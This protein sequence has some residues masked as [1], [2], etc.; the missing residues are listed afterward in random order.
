[1][2]RAAFRV[3][4][5]QCYQSTS[6]TQLARDL[7][8]TKSALYRHFDCKEA[9]ENAMYK[10]YYDEYAAFLK[11]YCDKALNSSDSDF[12]LLI[13][14]RAMVAYYARNI[15]AF[16][17]AL[18]QVDGRRNVMSVIKQLQER[19]IDILKLRAMFT[20]NQGCP[21][22]IQALLATTTYWLAQFHR[23]RACLDTEPDDEQV[24]KLVM[25]IEENVTKGLG[26]ERTTVAR[27]DYER[28]EALARQ[29]AESA[30]SV[31]GNGDAVSAIADR[32][33]KAAA[34]VVAELG[35]DASMDMVA[36]RAGM[37]KSGLYAHFK[38]KQDML[39]Q[40][41]LTE[42]DRIFARTE[43]AMR[44]VDTV[45]EKLYMSIVS[46]A[47]YLRSYPEIL[48][49][50]DWV[51]T[52]QLKLNC[53]VPP[54]LYRIFDEFHFDEERFSHVIEET[55]N[56]EGRYCT[57][58]WIGFLIMNLL[59]SRPE[60]MDFVDIPDESVRLLYQVITCGMGGFKQ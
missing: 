53:S 27:L 16:L 55:N 43:A 18:V 46:I 17:F 60:D 52:R 35:P 58:R 36:Q 3:W 8:V 39:T 1:I 56:D 11:P 47:D 14:L 22:Q 13:I 33:L 23:N 4:G 34:S 49:A 48:L 26:Y 19:G 57:I 25:F 51:R 28:L 40:L 9:L 32:L 41:F 59:M 38:N 15:D 31:S 10:T 5:Q 21:T 50:M 30:P 44:L 6:L 54:R 12:A 42:F 7:G 45:E 24:N 29:S 37:S 2:V 20:Q